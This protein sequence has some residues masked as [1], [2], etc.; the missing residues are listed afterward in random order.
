MARRDASNFLAALVAVLAVVT[1]INTVTIF[2]VYNTVAVSGDFPALRTLDDTGDGERVL[3]KKP[4]GGPGGGGDTTAPTA[5]ISINNGAANTTNP[6]VTLYLSYSDSGSGVQDC[7]YS[8]D[9]P[10]TTQAWEPCTATK[11]WGLTSALGTKT[12]FYEVRDNA[13]NVKQVF[14]TIELLAPPLPA[15]MAVTSVLLSPANPT[16]GSI[17]TYTVNEYNFGPNTATYSSSKTIAGPGGGGGGGGCCLTL[18][19]NSGRTYNGSFNATANGTWTVTASVSVVSNQTDPNPANNQLSNSIFVNASPINQTGNL[20]VTSN[21]PSSNLYVDGVLKGVTSIFVTGL[22]PG[23]HSVRIT[24]SLYEDYLTTEEI[25]T[26][27]T[28]SLYAI[29]T[30][31]ANQTNQ[32]A[33]ISAYQVT[34]TPLWPVVGEVVTYTVREYNNGPGIATYYRGTQ[35]S[36]PR[37]GGGGGGPGSPLILGPGSITNYT[38]S[39]NTNSSYPANGTWKI[40]ATVTPVSADPNPTNNWKVSDVPVSLGYFTDMGCTDTDGGFTPGVTGYT[41]NLTYTRYDACVNSSTL[42]EYYCSGGRIN[43]FNVNCVAAGYFVGCVLI[44]HPA[45]SLFGVCK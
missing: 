5:S 24:K 45:S 14:D 2:T 7:R 35:I 13:L 23:F 29:L 20:Y 18:A 38:G 34:Y 10:P 26:G 36:G 32:T 11:A 27:Q 6:N 44:N 12:V 9:A 22:S 21:P 31:L 16:V 17:V 4:G 30:P 42:T 25:F 3:P 1:I 43:S 41:H 19:P 33:D 40:N 37:G 39:F 15:D 28:T 8:N